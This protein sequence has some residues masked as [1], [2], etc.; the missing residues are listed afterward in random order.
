MPIFYEIDLFDN[1]SCENYL[2]DVELTDFGLSKERKMVK[3]NR[4]GSNLRLR[5]SKENKSIYPM[6]DE[7]GYTTE[8]FMIFRS[9]WDKGYNFESVFNKPRYTIS[10]EKKINRSNIGRPVTVTKKYTL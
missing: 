1:S 8:D 4:K 2:F 10:K 5:N 3:V 7:F 9:T 6:I